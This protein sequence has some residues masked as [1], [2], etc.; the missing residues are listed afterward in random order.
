[1]AFAFSEPTPDADFLRGKLGADQALAFLERVP[2]RLEGE[3]S[4]TMDRLREV[5][6]QVGGGDPATDKKFVQAAM[7]VLR[8][9]TT[10]AEVTPPLPES[11]ALIGKETALKRITRAIQVLAQAN[12]SA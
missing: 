2:E 1:V 3:P 8:V 12:P 5:A 7:R 9:A 4:Q 11:I 10:G 6:L